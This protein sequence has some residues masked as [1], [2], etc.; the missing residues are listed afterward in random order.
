MG[1]FTARVIARM[2][3]IANEAPDTS[4]NSP[5]RQRERRKTAQRAEPTTAP[6]ISTGIMRANVL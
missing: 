2:H 4:Q 6:M 1:M 5:V 3:I